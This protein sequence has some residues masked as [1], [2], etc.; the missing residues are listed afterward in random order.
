ML[1]NVHGIHKTLMDYDTVHD[2]CHTYVTC[3]DRVIN[4]TRRPKHQCEACNISCPLI[5]SCACGMNLCPICFD[6]GIVHYKSE[7]EGRF[8]RMNKID[9]RLG[10]TIIY[11]IRKNNQYDGSL[12]KWWHKKGR[13][14]D[15]EKFKSINELEQYEKLK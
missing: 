3:M 8:A 14:I 15:W 10:Q 7:C 13:H 6:I 12:V 11:V 9:M 5:Y 2:F 4:T 1:Y